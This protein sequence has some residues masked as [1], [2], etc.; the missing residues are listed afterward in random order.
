MVTG[1][2]LFTYEQHRYKRLRE[3]L[4]VISEMNHHVR[5]ALQ[6]ILYA[7][8]SSMDR[9]QQVKVVR[10]CVGRIQWALREVLPSDFS[11]ESTSVWPV[12]QPPSKSA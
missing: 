2:V 1:L 4:R 6:P 3:R 12:A 7:P 9:E 5:N 10:D 11:E 8:Q